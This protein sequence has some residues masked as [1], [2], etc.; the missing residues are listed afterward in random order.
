MFL[1]SDGLADF[2]RFLAYGALAAAC[3]AAANDAPRPYP[4]ALKTMAAMAIV[5][6]VA[7]AL[8]VAA[9]LVSYGR[10]VA[11]SEGWYGERRPIQ[12]AAILGTVAAGAVAA[13]PL[14]LLAG[15]HVPA[16][17]PA[18]VLLLGLLCYLV[19]RGISLHQVD[20]VL[21]RR[22]GDSAMRVGDLVELAWV[23]ALTLV[24]LVARVPQGSANRPAPT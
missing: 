8:G 10:E 9:E 19:V 13:L 1:T 22:P 16:L 3:L 15:R 4:P 7:L 21:H 24:V 6:G 11:G 2:A 20:A 5:L 23:V 17:R 12:A 18:L 14:W